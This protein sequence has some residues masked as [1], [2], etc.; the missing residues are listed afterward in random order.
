MNKDIPARGTRQLGRPK[1]ASS[2]RTMKPLTDKALEQ[3]LRQ[4]SKEQLLDLLLEDDTELRRRVVLRITA[5]GDPAAALGRLRDAIDEVLDIGFVEWKQL[6]AYMGRLGAVQ[7]AVLLLG[8]TAPA[9]GL[10]AALYFV[11]RIPSVF[12]SVHDECELE[13]FCAQLAEAVLDLTAKAGAPL[14]DDARKLLDAFQQDDTCR[15]GEVPELLGKQ[16]LSDGD[17]AALIEEV[18]SRMAKADPWQAEKLDGLRRKLRR[19][20]GKPREKNK[21]R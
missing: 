20:P 3:Y 2:K 4:W 1:R 21:G 5:E 13:Y 19:G 14:L 6:A 16:A 11:E 12:D 9:A 15:F 7:D 18:G 8:E 17:R 10:D